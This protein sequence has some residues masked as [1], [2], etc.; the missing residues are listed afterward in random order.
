M[1]DYLILISTQRKENESVN[2]L[3]QFTCSRGTIK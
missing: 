2:V 1:I 3:G